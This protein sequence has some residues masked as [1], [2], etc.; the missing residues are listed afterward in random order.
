VA[1]QMSATHLTLSQCFNEFQLC[2]IGRELN[3]LQTSHALL[4]VKLYEPD[5]EQN[6]ITW[7]LQCIHRQCWH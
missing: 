5:K 6:M 1:S 7:H 4:M 2:F 3:L